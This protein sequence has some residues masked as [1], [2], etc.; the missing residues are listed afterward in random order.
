MSAN[1]LVQKIRSGELDQDLYALKE[2]CEHRLKNN[3]RSR[4]GPGAIVRITNTRPK[5]LVGCNAIVDHVNSETATVTFDPPVRHG[6]KVWRSGV[7]VPLSCLE[8]VAGAEPGTVAPR[9]RVIEM[10]AE[11]RREREAMRR[12]AAAEAAFERRAN[13]F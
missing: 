8:V 12:E 10:D 9:R 4:L 2:A 6:H 1:D 3:K 5:Y 7:R 13:R 11:A